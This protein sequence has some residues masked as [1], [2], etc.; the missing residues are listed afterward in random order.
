MT[1]IDKNILTML[2]AEDSAAV[3]KAII[4]AQKTNEAYRKLD[5]EG[6]KQREEQRHWSKMQLDH[7][8]KWHVYGASILNMISTAVIVILVLKVVT[9]L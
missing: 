3:S 4:E 9:A 7:A 8:Y 2:T 1:D 6:W 5:H